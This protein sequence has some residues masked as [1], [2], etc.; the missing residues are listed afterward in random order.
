KEYF[1]Y[2]FLISISLVNVIIYYLT[3]RGV[4]SKSLSNYKF[5]RVVSWEYGLAAVI[6]I[7]F[8]ISLL[9]FSI[10]NSGEKFEYSNFG[11]LVYFSLALVALW[12][13]SLPFVIYS[14]RIKI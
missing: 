14:A 9:F 5:Y 7:F 11:Y 3:G 4:G 12:V 2:F 13:I 10:F 6:N 1:F 8:T